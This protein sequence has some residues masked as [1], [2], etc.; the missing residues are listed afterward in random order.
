MN[1]ALLVVD[2][3][4]DFTEGGALP[5]AGG[6]ATAWKITEFL[7]G[8]KEMYSLVVASR[9]WHEPT[10][11]NGGHFSPEPDFVD[12]WPPHCVAG[13]DGAEYHP[14]LDVSQI[15]VHV[16]KGQGRPA[17]SAFEGVTD[18]GRSLTDEL[19]NA[20]ID[21]VDIVGIA[22]DHCVHATAQDAIEL[23][24]SVTVKAN[25][26]VGVN[27]GRSVESLSDLIKHGARIT[28]A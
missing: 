21:A 6:A 17:Y 1:R 14:E 20:Q 13:S 28:V 22:T 8:N 18:E 15:D 3:Q 9:D 27:P 10:G 26:C 16:R 5:C 12:T 7:N 24:F 4:S 19:R 11:D 2:V 23:G 25:M